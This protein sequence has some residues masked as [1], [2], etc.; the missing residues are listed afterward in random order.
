LKGK[1][2]KGIKYSNETTFLEHFERSRK[3]TVEGLRS[4]ARKY[5]I[6]TPL[7][8]GKKKRQDVGRG[9]LKKVHFVI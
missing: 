3:N 6:S 2:S 4:E 5:T 9:N 8:G 7:A 1:N